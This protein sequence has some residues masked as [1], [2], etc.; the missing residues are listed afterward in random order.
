MERIVDLRSDTFSLPSGAM[1]EALRSAPLGD[2]V[3][4]EDPTVRRLEALAAERT[5]KE[6]ALLVTSGT[7]GN[8]VSLLAHCPPGA[9]VILGASTDLYNHEVGGMSAVGGL[10]PRPVDDRAGHPAPEAITAAI[11]PDDVHAGPTGAIC[12]EDTHQRAGGLPVPLDRLAEISAV[13]RAH[14]VPLHADGARVFN[15][16]VALGVDAS[17]M[18][19][20]VDSVTF[21]LSKG[22]SCPAG[23]VVCGTAEFVGRA[24]RMRKMLGGGMRQA[25]WIAAAGIVAL[26]EGVDRLADDHANARALAD[27]L[28]RLPGIE[29][30][31]DR[32][33]TNIVYF[34]LGGDAPP[35]GAF[36]AALERQGVRCFAMGERLVRMV[37]YRGIDREHVEAAV[38]AAARALDAAVDVEA[39]ALGPYAV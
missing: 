13:A 25:G 26:E 9:E 31:P 18:L 27:G 32:V 11:R 16:A 35:A 2:D 24:R 19:S 23:S 36:V 22:L 10:M 39:G 34:G 14:D 8:L 6:A 29:L 28:A 3:Y 7:Q 4:A 12:I 37:T 38:A 17:A 5:G 20:S 1:Y 33:V 15:A 30:E 21:C